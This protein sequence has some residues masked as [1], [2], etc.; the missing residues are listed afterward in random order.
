MSTQI[1]CQDQWPTWSDLNI[2]SLKIQGVPVGTIKNLNSQ[3]CQCSGGY[4]GTVVCDFLQIGELRV[5][6]FHGIYVSSPGTFATGDYV[7]VSLPAGFNPTSGG[8]A[9]PTQ[10][11]ACVR[12]LNTLQLGWIKF[13][14][15]GN[16]TMDIGRVAFTGT[17]TYTLGTFNSGN[18]AI[19]P[20]SIS[21]VIPTL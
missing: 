16:G 9:G 14:G 18:N 5:I 10:I 12:D 11:S 4:T 3:V 17:G 2:N 8:F 19:Q 1:I 7:S 20:F 15:S 21:Y 13:G 6:N